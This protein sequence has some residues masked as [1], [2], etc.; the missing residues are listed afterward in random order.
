MIA[1][2]SK[3]GMRAK[4]LQSCPTLC[5]LMDCSP[6]AL[7]FMGFSGPEHWSRLPCPPP[8]KCRVVSICGFHL[9]FPNKRCWVPFHVL[10]GHPY[11][12]FE[13]MAI[14]ILCLFFNWWVVFFPWHKHMVSF[15]TS[16]FQLSNTNWRGSYNLILHWH[17][18][19]WA[20]DSIDLRTQSSKTG[21][22]QTPATRLKS[23]GYL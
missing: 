15:P 22:F 18:L 1:Y 4:S 19:E 12:F 2:Y 10:N 14:Q 13:E 9:R 5:D 20:S 23:P 7:L 8:S 6:Q 3:C 17:Y 21:P 16:L 11:I